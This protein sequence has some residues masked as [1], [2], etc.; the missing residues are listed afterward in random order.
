MSDLLW[1]SVQALFDP[2][3]MG[4]LPDVTV[5]DTSVQDWQAMFDLVQSSGWAWEYWVGV[6]VRPLPSASEVLSRPADADAAELHVWPDP[7]VLA[8]FRPTSPAEIDFDI[9]LRQL[10]GQNGV[11]TLCD[12][13]R[14]IGRCLGKPVTMAAEGDYDHPVLGFD[15]IVDRVVLLAEVCR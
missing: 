6:E 10:Q 4:A 12:F 14:V 11:D 13:F 1:D 8:I 15:P 9:D 2:D 5:P 7:G 3:L